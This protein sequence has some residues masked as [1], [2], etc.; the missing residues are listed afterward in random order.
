MCIFKP[1]VATCIFLVFIQGECLVSAVQMLLQLPYN[2]I[3]ASHKMPLTP[4]C[5]VA[6]I[7][8]P[9]AGVQLLTLSS[10]PASEGNHLMACPDTAVTITCSATQVDTLAWRSMPGSLV[11]GFIPSHYNTDDG[12]VVIDEYT[13]TLVK[14]TNVNGNVADLIS[15][16]EVMIDDI[17]NGTIVTCKAES[18]KSLTI[19][20]ESK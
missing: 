16:L 10:T 2:T 3:A 14:V 12:E 1:V 19:Y 11:H 9:A 4:W 7:Y 13:L 20:K 5:L 6:K 18:Q 15:D 17:V 8:G